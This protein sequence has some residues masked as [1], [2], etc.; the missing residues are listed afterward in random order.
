MLR[1]RRKNSLCSCRGGSLRPPEQG[2]ERKLLS[3]VIKTVILFFAATECKTRL[4]CG[5]AL[6]PRPYG[7]QQNLNCFRSRKAGVIP[8][9]GE[10]SRSDKG[11]GSVGGGFCLRKKPEGETVGRGQAPADTEVAYTARASPRPTVFIFCFYAAVQKSS[12]RHDI[13]TFSKFTPFCFLYYTILYYI[14]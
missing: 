10:M 13:F 12:L 5:R 4:P 2:A 11:D 8:L 7:V 1:L 14:I 3:S 9:A 6:K